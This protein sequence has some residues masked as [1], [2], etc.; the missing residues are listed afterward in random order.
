MYYCK[1]RKMIWDK[2][3]P[4]GKCHDHNPIV[5]SQ[6][7][8][9]MASDIIILLLPTH[10]LWQLSVPFARKMVITLLFATGL[11]CVAHSTLYNLSH[12]FRACA[13]SAMRILFTVKIA[14][15]ISMSDV[16]HNGLFIGLWTEAE[17]A[18]SFVV[19]CALCIPRLIQAKGNKLKHA[20]SYAS[21]PFSSIRGTGSNSI[22]SPSRKGTLNSLSENTTEALVEESQQMDQARQKPTG[23][24]DQHE[25]QQPRIQSRLS[26]IQEDHHIQVIPDQSSS[27]YSRSSN[28]SN[29]IESKSINEDDSCRVQPL[30]VSPRTSVSDSRHFSS[31][32][33]QPTGH[34]N[35]TP[36]EMDR[37]LYTMQQFQFE[38]YRGSAH[39]VNSAN[40]QDCYTSRSAQY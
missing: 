3:T 38:S 15:V 21:S 7:S 11:L 1:P 36:E 23:F 30:V 29:S 17:V 20:M 4:G 40:S 24:Q 33:S 28:Y 14:P 37:E 6:G 34:K 5:I 31:R 10:S 25:L 35:M 13:A 18:L 26:S 12:S 2:F 22:R 19:A 32:S 16:S 9:N 39:S 8:F 27:N